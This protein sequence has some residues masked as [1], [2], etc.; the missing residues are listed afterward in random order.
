MIMV[1]IILFAAWYGE[2]A[3]VPVLA[4]GALS[5][6]VIDQAVDLVRDFKT[7]FLLDCSPRAVLYAQALGAALSV[8]SAAVLYDWY[9]TNVP[10]PTDELPAVVAKS[11][12]GLAY[13]FSDGGLDALPDHCLTIA[14]GCGAV[15]VLFDAARDRRAAHAGDSTSLRRASSRSDARGETHRRL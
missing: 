10:L 7:A 14:L 6:A 5:T 4:L 3:V 11:Y 1:M 9:V 12:R 8:V 2:P 13:A 15:A